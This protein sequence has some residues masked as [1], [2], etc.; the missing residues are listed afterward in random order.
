MTTR[1]RPLVYYSDNGGSQTGKMIDCPIA[2]ALARQ[3]I[4]HETGI[5]GNPQARDYRA[6]GVTFY[7][8][9]RQYPTCTARRGQPP[10]QD[11]ETVE[12]QGSGAG[13]SSRRFGNC[14]MTWAGG[15]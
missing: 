9:A 14:W 12:P 8:L 7:S 10:P 11:V 6:A 15:E 13:L 5:H 1:A 2:G 3:G 4:A